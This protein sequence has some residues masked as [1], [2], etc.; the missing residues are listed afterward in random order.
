MCLYY[1]LNLLLRFKFFMQQ[2]LFILFV[3]SF[4]RCLLTFRC[5]VFFVVH[6][7]LESLSYWF[8][9]QFGF[10]LMVHL[11]ISSSSSEED[12]DVCDENADSGIR[13]AFTFALF[14]GESNWLRRSLRTS[15]LPL[16]CFLPRTLETMKSHIDSISAF[17]L[18]TASLP[19]SDAST[20]SA[21]RLGSCTNILATISCTAVANI[22]L[23]T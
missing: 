19:V 16:W 21:Y 20:S 12:S 11:G 5:H 14:I 4:F 9:L 13:D 18:N 22:A 17:F 23:P 2:F 3:L 8:L 1:I 6:E 7:Q 15:C 10:V